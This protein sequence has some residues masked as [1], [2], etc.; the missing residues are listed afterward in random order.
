MD[1]MMKKI[2]T[3]KDLLRQILLLEQL[4][5]HKMITAKQLAKLID[6]TERT[7]FSDITYIRQQLPEGWPIEA[8]S[9]GFALT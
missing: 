6:T 7:V 5:N 4:A 2:I 8:A 3:E 9:N 1:G